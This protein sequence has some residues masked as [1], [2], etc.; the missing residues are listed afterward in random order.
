M[1]RTQD[2]DNQTINE[3]IS[4]FENMSAKKAAPI[5]ESG[6]EDDALTILSNLKSD[7]LASYWKI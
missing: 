3:I 2:N 7:I 6:M 1:N 4:T 5:I